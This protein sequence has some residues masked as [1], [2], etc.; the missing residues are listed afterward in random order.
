MSGKSAIAE[1]KEV[2]N[3]EALLFLL[4]DLDAKKVLVAWTLYR[5]EFRD[6]AR[7][8]KESVL[9]AFWN[10]WDESEPVDFARLSKVAGVPY[11]TTLVSF[12]RFRHARLVYPDGTI[13]ESALNI[14]RAE[15]GSYIKNLLPRNQ[16]PNT[17]EKADGKNGTKPR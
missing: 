10:L 8:K 17:G 6:R 15:V 9:E 3:R 4:D 1:I 14:V 16:R 13:S 7:G 2:E 12:E 11:Q 5:P